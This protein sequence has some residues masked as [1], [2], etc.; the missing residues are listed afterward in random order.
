ML[1][2]R[3]IVLSER[4]DVD[5]SNNGKEGVLCHYWFFNHGFK[6][7][8]SVWNGCLIWQCCVSILVILLLLLLKLMISTVVFMK[9]ANLTQVI[10]QKM[11][12]LMSVS[13]W[14]M[15]ANEIN[16]KNKLYSYY[17]DNLIKAKKLETKYFIDEKKYLDLT[18][19]F[20]RCVHKTL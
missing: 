2:D 18:F 19:Y 14:K 16:I 1:H 10:Y 17:F 12:C 15:L 3:R 6:F 11:F 5:K 9:L 13:I 4:N 8:D 20:T 7:Q